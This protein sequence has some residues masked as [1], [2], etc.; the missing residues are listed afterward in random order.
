MGE[1]DRLLYSVSTRIMHFYMTNKSVNTSF[2]EYIPT[3]FSKFPGEEVLIV[4]RIPNRNDL[5][6]IVAGGAVI[7]DVFPVGNT[8]RGLR[9][10]GV[11]M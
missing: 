11:F 3:F 8:L 9:E 7:D 5:C 1:N 4:F 6:G 2:S 10:S